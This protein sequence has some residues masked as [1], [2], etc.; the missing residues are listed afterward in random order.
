M[1][2]FSKIARRVLI[3]A[4]LICFSGFTGCQ[5]PG[6]T[7]DRS[8]PPTLLIGLDGFEW[9]VAI[10]LLAG[11]D[12]PNIAGLMRRG[13]YGKL[14][15]TKPTLSPILWTSIATGVGSKKHGITGFVKMARDAEGKRQ[16]RLFTSADRR[17]K[18]FWNIFSDYD[19]RIE[20]LGWWNTFPAET[21]NGVMVAQVNTISP[22]MRKAGQGI[23]KG[24]LV[25]G[26]EGQVYP[27]QRQ[28]EILAVVRKVESQTKERTES[29]LGD[30]LESIDET[31]RKFLEQSTWSF[32]ADSIYHEV[33]LKLLADDR[34]SD[35]FAVY[36]GG[37]DVVGHR[38]WRYAYPESFKYPP[39]ASELKTAG[40]ILKRYYVYLDTRIGE[41]LST[42]PQNANV[43][44]VSD[45]GMSAIRR[46]SR[47]GKPALSGGHNHGPPAFL[48]VAGPAF[49]QPKNTPNAL[50][51]SPA[52]I[53]TLGSILDITPT[54]LTLH[55]IPVGEDMDGA[56]LL[57]LMNDE[58]RSSAA[59]GSVSTH[60]D[61]TWQTNRKKI[62]QQTPETEE[63][64]EQLRS[65]GYL[66]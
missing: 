63:R 42:A 40:V 31:T 56:P 17:T 59:R 58:T 37:A 8:A 65:L 53:A 62:E 46:S 13:P 66:D 9:S 15:V 34:K 28:D 30:S 47:F 54:L 39:P 50:P 5:Q 12:L 23:W 1:Y 36:Y 22:A 41:L 21:V 4:L 11:G 60:T 14:E 33:A 10:E 44:L 24:K 43:I 16:Q 61:R 64:L 49:D 7:I 57:N 48:V 38:F 35:L 2:E 51:T 25:E 45:H 55:G 29:I 32:R 20:V 26:L 27:P 3:V 18:A 52:E 6:G 19:G